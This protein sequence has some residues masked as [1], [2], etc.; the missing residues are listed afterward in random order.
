MVVVISE[1]AEGLRPARTA[2]GWLV[3]VDS[4]A[5]QPSTLNPKP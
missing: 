3:L 5:A 2:A 1:S 4:L